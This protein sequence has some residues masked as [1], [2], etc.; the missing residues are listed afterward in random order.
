VR[1]RP[2]VAAFCVLTRPGGP[3][4]TPDGE[5]TWDGRPPGTHPVE[6]PG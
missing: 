4:L 1:I 2:H 6:S 3:V 5:V